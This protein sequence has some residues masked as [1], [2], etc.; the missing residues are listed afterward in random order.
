MIV[1]RLTAEKFKDDLSGKGAA[2]FGGRWNPIGL[3]VLYTSESRALANLELIVHTSPGVIPIDYYLLEIEMP[4][5][6]PIFYVTEANLPKEWR[7]MEHFT[8]LVGYDLI[9]QHEYLALKVPSASVTHE[10]NFVLNPD[11]PDFQQIRILR[12]EPYTFDERLFFK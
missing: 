1:F 4:D 10:C 7:K 5:D 12:A 11:H 8:Q 6:A 2:I 3:A 9:R